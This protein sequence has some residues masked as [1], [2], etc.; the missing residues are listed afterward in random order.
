[1]NNRK[2]AMYSAKWLCVPLV[3]LFPML[4]GC[5]VIGLVGGMISD[6][7]TP[8]SVSLSGMTI[9]TLRSGTE[10]NV[11]RRQGDTLSG[12]FVGLRHDSLEKYQQR[13]LT[14]CTAQLPSEKIPGPQDTIT[15]SQIDG[16]T[17]ETVLQAYDCQTVFI[18]GHVTDRIEVPYSRIKAVRMNDFTISGEDLPRRVWSASVPLLSTIVIRSGQQPAGTK[19]IPLSE[20]ACVAY[21]N[22]KHGALI[23]LGCGLAVDIIL[24]IAL[25]SSS[26]S[27]GF[28]IW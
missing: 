9:T 26:G 5:S 6:N 15:I 4:Q 10:I 17:F 19:T 28:S 25:R 20:V 23:G 13:L 11:V 18:K 12:V 24:A 22:S 14:F 16:P 2:A 1:M 21:T 8:D 7:A 27:G 3:L